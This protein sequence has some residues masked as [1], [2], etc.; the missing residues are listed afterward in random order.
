MVRGALAYIFIVV[1]SS[2]SMAQGKNATAD[3]LNDILEMALAGLIGPVLLFAI[4]LYSRFRLIKKQKLTI[5][6]QQ[7]IVM[8]ANAEIKALS[9]TIEDKNKY[10]TESIRYAQRIQQA[11]LPSSEYCNYHL[12]E[13]FILFKP[14]DIVSGDFYW[15]YATPDSKVI[16]MVAD[17]TGHGVPGAFMSMIGNSLLNEIVIQKRVTKPGEILDLLRVGVINAVGGGDED[18]TRDG[19][20]GVI[21]MW[22]K[23]QNTL[24]FAGA[25]NSL[26]LYR[27]GVHN[28][29]ADDDTMKYYGDDLVEFKT[30]NQ[31]ISMFEGKEFPFNTH[32][33]QLKDGDHV[34]TC[35]DGWQN[36]F[37]GP[38]NKEYG[39][40]GVLEFL[41]SM[42]DAK[43]KDQG[44]RINMG[45]E[46]WK[47]E[48]DQVDDICIIGVQ[49]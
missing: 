17:C 39:N 33:I 34:Y 43:I 31:P 11:I 6:D 41:D 22:D 40:K 35:S 38:E 37:G 16:W 13:H 29:A 20:D 27:K 24:D 32:E 12:K 46:D 30:D 4:V 5:E 45:I 26:Y 9:E 7:Q 49:V 48:Q 36:Q 3:S 47:G 25:Y 23:K 21:C 19:M 28:K 10:I 2:L 8:R 18:N 42:Q 44:T 14:K 1:S 15:L